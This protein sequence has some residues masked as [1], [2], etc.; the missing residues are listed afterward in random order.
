MITPPGVTVNIKN[1]CI[2]SPVSCS[3]IAGFP[4][5]HY[6][7]IIL[8]FLSQRKH[9]N[10]C[11]TERYNLF[12]FSNF[13]FLGLNT[14][15]NCKVGSIF[16]LDAMNHQR[17]A[18]ILWPL[19]SLPF[20]STQSSSLRSSGTPC[21][22][23]HFLDSPWAIAALASLNITSVIALDTLRQRVSSS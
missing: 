6:C 7:P 13:S 17:E 22:H 4:S 1:N 10:V 23:W 14:F 11:R 12:L 15:W 18:G 8:L 20:S 5:L 19:P 9:T 2:H 21:A 16:N 3:F